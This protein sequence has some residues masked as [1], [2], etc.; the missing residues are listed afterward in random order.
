MGRNLGKLEENRGRFVREA[1]VEASFYLYKTFKLKKATKWSYFQ[2]PHQP[3]DPKTGRKISVR[4]E[5][6]M[7]SQT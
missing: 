2:T 3:S 7:N 5:P 1:Q 4:V 6:E